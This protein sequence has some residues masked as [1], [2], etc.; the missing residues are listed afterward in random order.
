MKKLIFSLFVLLIVWSC[1]PSQ[2]SGSSERHST[3]K[4]DSTEYEITI[5]DNDFDQ[6]YLINYS[7]AKDY[8][9][10]YYRGKN[11]VAV[12]NWNDYFTRNRYHRVIEDYIFY[13]NSVDYGIDVNRKLYWYFKYIEDVSKI[14]LFR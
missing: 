3:I 2:K 5:I 4:S 14:R 1:T 12:I 8:S 10:E 11:Q 13:D 7:P 9:N 6:W